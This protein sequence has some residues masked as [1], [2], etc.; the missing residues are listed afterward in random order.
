[1]LLVG[2]G[3]FKL[4]GNQNES[5]GDVQLSIWLDTNVVQIGS[6]MVLTA[7]LSNL[8]EGFISSWP[9][10]GNSI[11]LINGKS[12]K[13][14]KVR[15][16]ISPYGSNGPILPVGQGHWGLPSRQTGGWAEIIKFDKDI[17]PGN[18]ELQGKLIVSNSD[19]VISAVLSD[20]F[21][22]QIVK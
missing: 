16:Y 2:V 22:L 21:K 8:T 10:I 14:Y 20:K 18:Y 17:E 19:N 4:T 13:I 11:F 12:E 5:A 1:M 9:S 7:R 15:R 6:S 3:L